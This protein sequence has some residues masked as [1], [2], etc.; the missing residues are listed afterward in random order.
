MELTVPRAGAMTL[1]FLSSVAQASAADVL[2]DL[3]GYTV[4][5]SKTI[6]AFADKGKAKKD[7]F[8]GC[9]YDRVIIFTDGT[10]VT[11]RTYSYTYSYRPKA[12]IL[13]KQV[14]YQGTPLV[15]LKMVVGD[16]VFDVAGR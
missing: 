2:S 8:E 16:S 6:D 13:G 14:T 12:V 11:C 4:V 10:A 15:L 3:E 7:G 1:A 5:A 9:E